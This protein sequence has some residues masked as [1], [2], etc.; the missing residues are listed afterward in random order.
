MF[1][2]E[3]YDFFKSNHG[4]CFM[5]KAVL[6]KRRI[7]GLK[8]NKKIEHHHWILHIR[9]SL[10]TNFSLN[11]QFY[12]FG[13]NLPKKG[14]S[15]PKQ[16]KVNITIEFCIFELVYVPNFSLNWQFWFFFWPDL[17]KKRVSGGKKNRT[18]ACVHD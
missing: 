15:G 16:K 3:I 12:F 4:R 18:C 1:S 9:I 8:Q 7:S 11:W 13:T 2:W 6:T 5:R 14:V 17:T 10:G